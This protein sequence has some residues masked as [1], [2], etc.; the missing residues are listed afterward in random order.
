MNLTNTIGAGNP[1]WKNDK[2]KNIIGAINYLASKGCNVFSFLTYN[3]G[4]DGDDVWPFTNPTNKLHYDCSKL[5]QWQIVFDYAQSLGFYL[6]FKMQE[7]ENDDND[8]G[9][10]RL[11]Q[12]H[13]MVERLVL[14]ENFIVG[15]L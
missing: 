9:R 13:L 14:K 11:S 7:T 3:V 5:D 15:N 1:V 4:G 8:M 6:H 10:Q 2:G 12:L